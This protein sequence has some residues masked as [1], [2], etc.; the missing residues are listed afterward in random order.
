[1][2][3]HAVLE[4]LKPDWENQTKWCIAPCKGSD[5]HER[6]RWSRVTAP[7][8]HFMDLGDRYTA[9]EIEAFC[10][11]RPLVAI[12]R[13]KASVDPRGSPAFRFFEVS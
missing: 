7:G 5:Q 13:A 10:H 11:M 3:F 6:L 1:M 9:K 12:K 8:S 4:L 2:D